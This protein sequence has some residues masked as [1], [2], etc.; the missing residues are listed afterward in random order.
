[1]SAVNLRPCLV[2][3]SC[4]GRKRG[5]AQSVSLADMPLRV[6]LDGLAKAWVCA[7]HRSSGERRLVGSYYAGRGFS[8]AL[9]VAAHLRAPL[10]VVSAGLGLIYGVDEVPPYDLTIGGGAGSI[11]ERLS[12]YGRTPADWWDA[13]NDARGEA[14]PFARLF[15]RY[16][17]ATLLLA[18]PGTYLAMV[19]H[20]LACLSTSDIRRIRI[21]TS[22]A[23]GSA[24]PAV[25]ASQVMPY[26]PRLESVLPGTL[27]DFPQRALNHFVLTLGGHLV[28]TEKGRA[29]VKDSMERS[30]RRVLPKRTRL[31]DEEICVVLRRQWGLH[32]GQSARLLRYLR[33]DALVSCEQTRFR[34]LWLQVGAEFGEDR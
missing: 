4:T 21:F 14:Y 3:T 16:A 12:R 7:L 18:L 11:A 23:G 10:G 2:V 15:G 9:T 26:D 34:K 29:L 32:H 8:E 19:Q 1:M 25:L 24:V 28:S 17:G 6:D 31:S 33:D 30:H 13:L 20:E 5:G 22:E 27:N